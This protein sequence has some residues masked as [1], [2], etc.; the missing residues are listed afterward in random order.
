MV[1][2]LEA[3]TREHISSD[4]FPLKPKGNMQNALKQL[5]GRAMGRFLSHIHGPSWIPG[6]TGLLDQES[7]WPELED[8][9]RSF[10]FFFV[11]GGVIP[12]ETRGKLSI[13]KESDRPP[14]PAPGS[15]SRTTQKAVLSPKLFFLSPQMGKLVCAWGLK[16]KG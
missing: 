2:P 4:R 9:A 5:E 15:L 6:S 12:I 10:F 16:R 13:F 8:Q 11:W 3:K 1:K 14:P 7:P